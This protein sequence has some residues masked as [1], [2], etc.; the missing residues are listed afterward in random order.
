MAGRLLISLW[1]VS[2][3]ALL[4]VAE[5]TEDFGV[6]HDGRAILGQ[7]LQRVVG[8]RE[9]RIH[10]RRYDGSM[11]RLHVAPAALVLGVLLVAARGRPCPR[12][13]RR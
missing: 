9:L 4:I 11:T 8:T 5:P 12:S 2:K 3:A 6:D 1:A 10:E 13:G 7:I